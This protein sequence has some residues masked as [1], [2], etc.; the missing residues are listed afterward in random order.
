M[1]ALITVEQL[2]S[3]Y[4]FIIQQDIEDDQLEMS[5]ESASVRL[6]TWV[7]TEAYIDAAIT[8]QKDS[9]DP[10]RWIILRNVEGHLTMHF[11]ILGLNTN[12]R[13]FGLVAG[14]QVEGN[15]VNTY[16]QPEKV[17]KFQMMYLEMARTIAEPYLLNDGTPTAPFER[18]G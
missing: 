16:F 2:R 12:L 14:E 15:A 17:E 5:V 8:E 1:A 13:F 7:S 4:P 6:Q 3:K 18:V 10:Q 9:A 11:A